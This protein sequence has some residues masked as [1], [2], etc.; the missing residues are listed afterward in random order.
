MDLLQRAIDVVR[1]LTKACVDAKRALPPLPR[2]RAAA[3]AAAAAGAR[4]AGGRR[5]TSV[6]RAQLADLARRGDGIWR[7]LEQRDGGAVRG[8]AGAACAATS[9]VVGDGRT[10]L[11][12]GRR[13]RN[14]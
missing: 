4:A 8:R 2:A 7:G 9:F 1:A 3:A 12:P 6:S 10:P 11:P 5:P 14:I 13:R